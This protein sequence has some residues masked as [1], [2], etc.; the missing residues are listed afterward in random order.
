MRAGL[1]RGTCTLDCLLARLSCPL[2][3]AFHFTV[4]VQLKMGVLHHVILIVTVFSSATNAQT[5]CETKYN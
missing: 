5:P 1:G 4:S 2:L 3:A